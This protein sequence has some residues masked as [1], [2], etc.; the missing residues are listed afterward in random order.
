MNLLFHLRQAHSPL[1]LGC[2]GR[3]LQQ[4]DWSIVEMTFLIQKDYDM[5]IEVI[6]ES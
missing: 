5:Q 3:L 2:A 6:K 1:G 4:T